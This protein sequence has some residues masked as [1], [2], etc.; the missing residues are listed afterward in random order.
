MVFENTNS[1]Y[2]LVLSGVTLS[3]PAPFMT[4]RS[5]LIVY[6][7]PFL[8]LTANNTDLSSQFI[9]LKDRHR[10]GVQSPLKT[11]IGTRAPIQSLLLEKSIPDANAS[12]LQF[13]LFLLSPPPL[14]GIG[15]RGSTGQP[16]PYLSRS[17][18]RRFTEGNRYNDSPSRA[19]DC[20]TFLSRLTGKTVSP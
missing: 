10:K 4:C 5:V 18:S 15:F 12:S 13:R 9:L 14:V 3:L 7:I 16:V 20:R 11:K 17:Y 1:R 19:I 6:V 8:T 2:C